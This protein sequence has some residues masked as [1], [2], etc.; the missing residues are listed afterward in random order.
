MRQIQF[1]PHALRKLRE[2][3]ILVRTIEEVFEKPDE[4][5]KSHNRNVVYR[6]FGSKYLL[7]VY[8]ADEKLIKVITIFWRDDPNW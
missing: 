3:K 1:T 6:K 2:R 4:S 7:V 5:F 8:E